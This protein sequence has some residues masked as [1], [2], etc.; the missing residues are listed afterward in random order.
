MFPVRIQTVVA[1]IIA[2]LLVATA[3]GQPERPADRPQRRATRPDW[4][5]VD[6]SEFF[7]AD[8]AR[9][10]LRGP[11]PADWGHAAPA[12]RPGVASPPNPANTAA[13]KFTWSRLISATTLEDLV[14]SQQIA[15]QRSITQ[16]AAFAA[17]GHQ[18][19]RDHFTLLATLFGMIEQFDGSVRWQA[20]AETA[21]WKCQ[22]AAQQSQ[23]GSLASFQSATAVRDELADLLRGESLPATTPQNGDERRWSL[24]RDVLMRSLATTLNDVIQPITAREKSFRERTDEVRR[25]G[26]WTAALAE[27][28]TREGMEDA[29]DE[30]YDAFCRQLQAAAANVVRATEAANLELAQTATGEIIQSCTACHESYR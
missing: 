18:Q 13:A 22:R 25:G 5:Q 12:S 6:A 17:G 27:V 28:L 26:E 21:R 8:P 29:G 7:F 9:D 15:L 20:D 11:R 10:G 16:P 3:M 14:K 1:A 19:A 4:S 30:E 23:V 2:T 24:D